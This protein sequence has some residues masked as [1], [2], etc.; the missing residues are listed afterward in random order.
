MIVTYNGSFPTSGS[1]PVDATNYSVAATITILGNTGTLIKTG[2]N[3]LGWTT[4]PLGYGT[5]YGPGL[6][7]TYTAAAAN[8]ILYAKWISKD[9]N[10]KK[11]LLLKKDLPPVNDSNKHSIRYRV[12][13]DDL[14]RA[15]AWSP[16]YYVDAEPIETVA[17]TVT[18]IGV[19]T[20]PAGSFSVTWIDSV[21]VSERRTPEKGMVY[22]TVV[23]YMPKRLKY[24]I[25]VKINSATNYSYHGTAI[26]SPDK[27]S[28][29]AVIAYTIPNTATSTIK[30][31]IQPEGISKIVVPALKLYESGTITIP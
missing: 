18:K 16:I 2:Y 31:L 15:S 12:V 11:S 23:E 6:A 30:I 29:P 9:K 19:T 7:T 27:G 21:S 8:I 26:A 1:V 17:A 13:S 10:I 22:M 3:F 20:A 14:N 24:D 25:F 28:Q 5:L 4:N